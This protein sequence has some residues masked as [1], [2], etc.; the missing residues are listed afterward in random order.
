M[1]DRRIC[2]NPIPH[3]RWQTKRGEFLYSE[4]ECLRLL[5]VYLDRA[6]RV[7]QRE[8]EAGSAAEEAE[9]NGLCPGLEEEREAAVKRLD[10]AIKR[11]LQQ[12]RLSSCK[13][14]GRGKW[15]WIDSDRSCGRYNCHHDRA[16]AGPSGR[17]YR[18][19]DR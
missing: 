12:K 4:E 3:I 14:S 5:G 9:D 6:K 8:R 16:Y 7:W 1:L 2:K 13:S 17:L 10:K 19:A 18:R 15:F 11:F